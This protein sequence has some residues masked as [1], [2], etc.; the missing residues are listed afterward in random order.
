MVSTYIEKTGAKSVMVLI[1][2]VSRV[3]GR[4]KTGGK[5][6]VEVDFPKMS[7]K[8]WLR[9]SKIVKN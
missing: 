8:T 9:K 4:S 3:K 7:Q 6:K 1:L 5:E 2:K